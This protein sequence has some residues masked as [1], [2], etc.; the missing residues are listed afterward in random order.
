[1]FS[2]QPAAGGADLYQ[3]E[4][5]TTL[6]SAFPNSR[7]DS[8]AAH[9]TPANPADP[10]MDSQLAAPDPTELGGASAGYNPSLDDDWWSNAIEV[11]TFDSPLAFDAS[12][13]GLWNGHFVPPPPRP[14]FLDESVAAD[15]LTTC[16]LCTWAW[17]RNAYS[18]DG[19]IDTTG[20][21]GWVFTLIVV[22]I[23]SGLIGAIVMVIFLRCRRIKSANANGGRPQPW[24]CRNNR[25]GGGQNRS[26]IS[27]K[28]SADSIRRPTSNSGVWTWLGGSRRSSAGPDQ[29]GPPSTSPAENHYTHMDD[30][31][32]P[33]GVSE[34]LYAE[35]D[36][37][38][39][40]SAN[41]SYQNT[42]YSQCG[43]KY[44]FQAHEQDIPMVVSSAPSSAYYS[45]LSVTAMPGGASGSN[46]GAYEIV[47]LNVMSQPLPNWEHHGGGGGAGGGNGVGG[48]ATTTGLAPNDA[49]MTQRRM[50]RLAAIN[51]TSTS[52]VPSDY[53]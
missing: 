22:S 28:H 11:D 33:V 53:V 6:R 29:I 45:D 17:Q 27:I 18:L 14:P 4:A 20:E 34:A 47:G 31:Y 35:L 21:L 36:R 40:R 10:S 42:A 13:N 24:W 38:S 2:R 48:V 9:P 46:Q 8:L 32:S 51:E 43:E 49:A 26:P 25:N 1:M 30:A 19:S 50:P 52:T 37:E 44:N 7:L 12:E 5:T 16:D 15:G 23:I 39:V 3:D 41:P